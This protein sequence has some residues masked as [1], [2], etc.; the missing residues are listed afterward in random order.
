LVG[1]AYVTEYLRQRSKAK[2]EGISR[3]K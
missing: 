3:K 1:L 2:S